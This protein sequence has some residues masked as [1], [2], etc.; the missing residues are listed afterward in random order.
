MTIMGPVRWYRW[1]LWDQSG[2]TDDHYG[3]RQVVQMRTYHYEGQFSSSPRHNQQGCRISPPWRMDLSC[4][5]W[6]PTFWVLGTDSHWWSAETIVGVFVMVTIISSQGSPH[7]LSQGSS[8]CSSNSSSRVNL[9]VHPRVYSRL[10]LR[11]HPNPKVHLRLH[12][13]LLAT[14]H[15]R[16]HA[17]LH[18]SLHPVLHPSY[19]P[20]YMPCNISCYI[21]GF[22]PR[23]MPGYMWG[24]MPGY[25]PGYILGY[26]PGYIPGSAHSA[27]QIFYSTTKIFSQ[28]KTPYFYRK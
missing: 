10:H 16:L 20:V 22:M 13:R 2:S 6:H 27:F 26:L 15:P 9:R 1:P 23:Y 17:M 18:P 4:R 12:A 19:M 5:P 25:I 24:Y 8:R 28:E 7:S 11:L 3:T 21:P 14:F